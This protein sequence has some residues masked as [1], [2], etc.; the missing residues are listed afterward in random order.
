MN[1]HLHVGREFAAM[2]RSTPI[3][4]SRARMG[5][6]LPQPP[7]ALT[8]WLEMSST[9]RRTVRPEIVEDDT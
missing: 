6:L 3:D 5:T 7:S 1:S 4:G 2:R 9:R 8:T